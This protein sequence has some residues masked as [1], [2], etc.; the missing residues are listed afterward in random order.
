MS[1][2]LPYARPSKSVTMKSSWGQSAYRIARTLVPSKVNSQNVSASVL[3]AGTSTTSSSITRGRGQTSHASVKSTVPAAFQT[4]AR[5][6]RKRRKKSS[7]YLKV[8]WTISTPYPKKQRGQQLINSTCNLRHALYLMCPSL[9]KADQSEVSQVRSENVSMS[10]S[11][12]TGS[13]K[14]S[15][16][17]CV[18][19]WL[20]NF[21]KEHE[22]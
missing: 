2:C 17:Q 20:I 3:P 7:V 16:E 15:P 12:K 11:T 18:Q 21:S 5:I 9:A 6:R 22:R 10:T 13:V 14:I 19:N 1:T 8:S 4:K